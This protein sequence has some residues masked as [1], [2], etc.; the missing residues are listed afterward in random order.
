[1]RD[2]IHSYMTRLNHIGWLQLVGSLKSYVSFAEYSLFYRALL[3]K[4][5]I[6]SRTTNR[7]HPISHSRFTVT[8]HDSFI[9]DTELA[10]HFF[11]LN[12]QKNIHRSRHFHCRALAAAGQVGGGLG[13]G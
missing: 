4:R 10:G 8:K 6:I 12:L 9:Y 1:M 5:P 2:M 11:F 7:S 3:Q 13:G